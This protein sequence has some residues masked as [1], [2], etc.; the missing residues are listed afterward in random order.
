MKRNKIELYLQIDELRKK[1]PAGDLLITASRVVDVQFHQ[2]DSKKMGAIL[3]GGKVIVVNSARP[4]RAQRFS[5]AH[6]LVHFYLHFGKMSPCPMA[7][8]QANEGAAELLM[9]RQ[10]VAK[11]VAQ[12]KSM[13]KEALAKALASLYEVSVSVA[14]YKLNSMEVTTKSVD[15]AM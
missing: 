2:F 11:F 4:A 13:S 10:Q 9:P 15:I 12:H 3:I 8:W 1:L 6:E 5:L 14:T 7:E